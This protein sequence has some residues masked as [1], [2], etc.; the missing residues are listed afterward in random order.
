MTGAA[1]SAWPLG[2]GLSYGPPPGPAVATEAC[3]WRGRV[4]KGEVHDEN[5]AALGGAAGHA[6][7]FGT[8]DGVLDHALAVL[9]GSGATPAMLDAIRNPAN[10]DRT[11]GWDSRHPGWPGGD[12]CSPGTIGH[13]GF[14]G[15]GLWIDFARGLA[16]TLLTN[17]VHPTRHGADAIFTLRL[18][19]GE[20]V[21]RAFDAL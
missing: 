3:A 16:W 20:A 2:E 21:V 4:L 14:T 10:G 7:L 9:D 13:T 17:R 6:G 5:A 11:C 1:L 18:E 12:A 19:V 15:T 8:V